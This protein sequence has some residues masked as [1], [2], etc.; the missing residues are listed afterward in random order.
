VRRPACHTTQSVDLRTIDG[1]P[2][3]ALTCLIPLLSCRSC[4]PHVP[5][6]ELV[7]L[8]DKSIASEPHEGTRPA[9]VERALT[10]RQQR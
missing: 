4:R 9:G 8:T 7:R 3:A 2:F 1:H 6:A 5:F 10:G